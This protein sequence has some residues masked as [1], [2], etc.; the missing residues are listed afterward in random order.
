ML[1]THNADTIPSPLVN[2]IV[3]T[4]AQRIYE[5]H[6]HDRNHF[7][8]ERALEE[9]FQ[10]SRRSIRLVLEMLEAQ[11]LIVRSARC[12]T[13]VRTE[14]A[15]GPP[16]V[17]TR[18]HTIGIGVLASPREPGTMAVLQGIA[19]ALDQEAYRLVIG[20]FAWESEKPV[21]QSEARFLEQMI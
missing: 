1:A 21:Q 7:P 13:L 10:V 6:Y 2:S 15:S 17:K 3:A 9:E 4:M 8:S 18:R 12:R 14:G 19:C 20:N 11:G 5:G 16:R